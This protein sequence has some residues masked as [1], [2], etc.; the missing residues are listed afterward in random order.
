MKKFYY[1]SIFILLTLF[2]INAQWI[3][4]KNIKQ[5]LVAIDFVD[6]HVG[7]VST[8]QNSILK[9]IDGGNTWI[10]VSTPISFSGLQFFDHNFGYAIGN[11][12][13]YKTNDGGLTW[14]KIPVNSSFFNPINLFFLNKSAG[15]VQCGQ[16]IF[17]TSDGGQSWEDKFHDD[18]VFQSF[19]VNEK[20]GWFLGT[21]GIYETIDG[22]KSWQIKNW[23]E[24][25]YEI[26]FKNENVGWANLYNSLGKT[27]DGGKTWTILYNNHD[28]ILAIN[29]FLFIDDYLGF[30][31][32]R[33]NFNSIYQNFWRTNDGGINWTKLNVFNS[34]ERKSS[35][36]INAYNVVDKNHIWM[37]GTANAGTNE[38]L[39]QIC[40]YDSTKTLTVIKSNGGDTLYANYQYEISWSQSNLSD[41]KGKLEFSTDQGLSW[42][43]IADSIKIAD[44]KYLWKTPDLSSSPKCLIKL[45][46]YSFGISDISDNV[47]NILKEVRNI[48]LISPKGGDKFLST[49]PLQIKWD[50]NYS[51]NSK[52]HIQIT[53]NGGYN[54]REVLFGGEW[55]V[56]LSD[57]QFS[58]SIPQDLDGT[59]RVNIF[60]VNNPQIRDESDF[61]RIRQP[62]YLSIQFASRIWT[63]CQVDSTKD[64]SFYCRY[65]PR[66]I[67]QYSTDDGQ[68]WINHSTIESDSNKILTQVIHWKIP[69]TIS[70]YCRIRA[71]SI[72]YSLIT[73]PSLQFE[74]TNRKTISKLPLEIGNKWFYK[75]Y[76][77]NNTGM[78]YSSES[79]RSIW[80]VKE[81]VLRNDGL[82][83]SKI[84]IYEA[85]GNNN[86][87]LHDSCFISQTGDKISFIGPFLNH[88]YEKL[89]FDF[90]KDAS[91][92]YEQ[93]FLKKNLLLIYEG[94][95]I[96]NTP[97]VLYD[98]LGFIL[99]NEL[100][101]Q[102]YGGW[103]NLRGFILNGIK[104]GEIL[105]DYIVGIKDE[106]QILPLS[107]SLSQNYPN[108]FNPSTTIEYSIPV[109]TLLASSLQ[110]VTLK[111]Y[112]ILGREVAT[113]VNEEE[114]PGNYEIKFDGSNLSSGAYFYRLRTGNYS[115]SKKLILMK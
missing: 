20:V 68:N 38:Y 26:F 17:Y 85:I 1:V 42:N 44:L 91:T 115:E 100:G 57:K 11:F 95:S 102:Y 87:Q 43:L 77:Y 8:N 37:I 82:K 60:D 35:F 30:G 45:T 69:N 24:R 113:L 98:S 13:I 66:V 53:Y 78:P 55:D 96:Y 105:E 75:Y 114:A 10:T 52:V 49:N 22:G 61:F 76:S 14:G 34:P 31:L 2:K 65:I 110:H 46:E 33:E 18:W 48:T 88:M 9:T 3:T 15:W 50:C 86:F 19:F 108:P 70:K 73:E 28:E 54:E 62:S 83:Y 59:F 107:F 4:Q 80:E 12:S 56:P 93:T 109:E 64:I 63:V 72:D 23:S 40:K 79:W 94:G 27:S 39:G 71:L 81:K 89:S 7:F 97:Y 6:E 5:L 101:N 112:D 74:I 25:C 67:F 47:F 29:K 41:S 106:Q 51:S 103:Y 32:F 104:Y 92:N 84:A 90:T 16:A 21:A 111:I 58:A 99:Y 36:N